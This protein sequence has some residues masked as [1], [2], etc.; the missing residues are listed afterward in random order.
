MIDNE[1]ILILGGCGGPNA[2]ST[3][4]AGTSTSPWHLGAGFGMGGLC[5][6][7]AFYSSNLGTYLVDFP[8]KLFN[9][10]N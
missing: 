5:T 10:F 3:W 6:L 7:V 9:C 4:G 8:E 1:T 2:V